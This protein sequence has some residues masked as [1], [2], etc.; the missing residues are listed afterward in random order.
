MLG[1]GHTSHKS[2]MWNQPRQPRQR[3]WLQEDAANR[4]DVHLRQAG[5]QL[6]LSA[7]NKPGSVGWHAASSL[8]NLQCFNSAC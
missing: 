8:C 4:D 2:R 7:V 1:A 3:Q 6:D 5:C